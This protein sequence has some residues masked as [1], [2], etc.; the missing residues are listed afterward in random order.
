M[1]DFIE[2]GK[3]NLINIENIKV[4]MNYQ[5]IPNEGKIKDI[6]KKFKEKAVGNI[7]VSKRE[8]GYYVVDGQH[9][10][11]AMA[12]LGYTKIMC[13]ILTNLT[14]NQEAELFYYL[15][16]SK[17]QTPLERYKSLKASGDEEIKEL[18]ELV[19]KYKFRI[20][21]GGSNM[22]NI[23]N[24]FTALYTCFKKDKYMLHK[25][26]DVLHRAWEG[27][28]PTSN[29]LSGLYYFLENTSKYDTFDFEGF[30]KQLSKKT[31]AEVYLLSQQFNS[32]YK[33]KNKVSY[34]YAFLNIYNYKRKNKFE[35]SFC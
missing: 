14:V 12:K 24:S 20:T 4:D 30:I 21:N 13:E 28:S 35:M 29:T 25:T 31:P 26:L 22:K 10:L 33:K 3:F 6:I 23:L 5:R 27:E 17:P 9:R 15:S 7:L 19:E 18:D 11:L 8:D 34:A 2:R 16:K 32:I 1:K